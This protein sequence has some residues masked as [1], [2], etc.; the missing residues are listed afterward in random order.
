MLSWHSQ[1]VFKSGPNECSTYPA[2]TPTQFV[3]LVCQILVSKLL[4]VK[5]MN[6]ERSM[7]DIRFVSRLH[8]LEEECMVIC[9]LLASVHVEEACDGFLA[10][11]DNIAWCERN[12]VG[13]PF[14]RL[15]VCAFR[16]SD[17][18]MATSEYRRWS[19]LESLELAFSTL[20]VFVVDGELVKLQWLCRLLSPAMGEVN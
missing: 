7:C 15:F 13:V 10:A 14:E 1:R 20:V 19:R 16:I 6:L 11:E 5:V 17:S 2:Y 9:I 3:A 12:G 4:Y 8:H 18:V